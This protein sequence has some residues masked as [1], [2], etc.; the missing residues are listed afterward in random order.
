V[1]IADDDTPTPTVTISA[2]DPSAAE[3]GLDSGAFTITRSGS[4]ATSLVVHFSVGGTATGGGDYTALMGVVTIPVGQAS[5]TIAL[6]PID[7]TRV[8]GSETVV[9][10]LSANRAYALGTSTT[11]TVTIADDDP[12]PAPQHQVY[13]PVVRR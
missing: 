4:T 3:A 12:A 11:A 7:D 8:E 9:V 2:S 6:V 1:T 13:L 10:T 5:A